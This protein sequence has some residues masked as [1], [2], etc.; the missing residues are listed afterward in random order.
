[1]NALNQ[2]WLG[3]L[4]AAIGP[5][6][7]L[8]FALV[9]KLWA[10][11][12]T[13]RITTAATTATVTTLVAALGCAL[14]VALAGRIEFSAA[15]LAGVN[16]GIYFDTLSAVIFLLVSFLGAV[17]TRYALT[18]LNGDASQGHFL[19]WLC[20]T[21]GAVLTLVVAGN[22]VM[23]TAA[24]IATSLGLNKLLTFYSVRPAALVAARKKYVISRLGDA[25]LILAIVFTYRV[26]GTSEWS[27]LFARAAQW[28]ESG[29]A[30]SADLTA[31]CLL[32]VAGAM[33]KSAQFPFHSWLP[34]TMETPTPVSALMH[35]GIINAGGFL[36][37]RLSPLVSLS[38]LALSML[39]I[40]GA[41]TAI[42]A[43][44]VMMTQ[45]SVKR[46]LAFSTIAQMGFMMLQCG[47]GAYSIAVLHIVAHSLYKAHA[48]LSSGSVVSISKSSWI[49]S[50]KTNAH[51]GALTA[52][53]LCAG[54]LFFAVASLFG[55]ALT[56]EP[57]TIVLGAV[58]VMSLT[59]LLWSLWGQSITPRLIGAGVALAGAVSVAYFALHLGFK[60]LLSGSLPH[61]ARPHAE[62]NDVL[63]FAVIALF[64]AMLVLQSQLPL[65]AARPWC[66]TLYVHARN[67]FYFNTLANRAIQKVWPAH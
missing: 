38:S 34:D 2:H 49:P 32:L 21:L 30:P 46:M 31:L 4:L 60:A 13:A 11:A 67:G 58:F 20:V 53:M 35:A 52:A 5:I 62:L 9:P 57:G 40:I 3:A 56:S 25:C 64:G 24:W 55:V 66:R 8:A 17:V 19:K 18:Y 47:L 12:H 15:L 65:W 23:F 61:A 43:S 7:L 29:A 28:S 39:A 22:L 27:E 14:W 41:F 59:H 6:L 42:F 33:L 54:L 1:M 45:A 26:F 48:F 63:A 36:I 37:I 51:P 10:N 16:I 50:G 44:L